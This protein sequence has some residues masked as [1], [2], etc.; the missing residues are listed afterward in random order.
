MKLGDTVAGQ[1]NKHGNKIK[2]GTNTNIRYI[3]T[4]VITTDNN[5]HE[6]TI[7]QQ[8]LAL[9]YKCSPVN[10]DLVILVPLVIPEAD[11]MC[12]FASCS[13]SKINK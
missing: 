2:G 9:Y 1:S 3:T 10:N 7:P 8:R 5:R 12:L 13:T 11:E 4:I 6:P